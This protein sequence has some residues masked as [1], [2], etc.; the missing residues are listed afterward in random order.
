M[1][2][3][4]FT[5]AVVPGILICYL[6]TKLD[7]Y[8]KERLP[9]LTISLGLGIGIF[10]VAR[11]AEGHFDEWILS[12]YQVEGFNPNTHFGTLF[13]SAFFR[14]GFI[15]EF[16]KLVVLLLIPF[17]HRKF[18]E[19]MDGIVYAVVIG[20]GFAVVE[21]IY[22]CM[23]NNEY[24]LALVR[25][26]TAVP[27]HAVFGVILGYYV[28]LAKFSKNKIKYILQGFLLAVGIH[29]LYDIFLFQEYNDSLMLLATGVLI[30]GLF[31]S[32]KLINTHQ[33]NSPFK[34]TSEE[35]LLIEAENNLNDLEEDNEILSGVISQMKGEENLKNKNQN[36]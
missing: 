17:N 21:N 26:F 14:V 30:G 10:F 28:G 11:Y 16:L 7:R 34:P 22:Y 23:P 35:E 15:E 2:L 36:P 18:N 9:L 20:M 3:L 27:S 5:L 12:Y 31:F 6:I 8:E 19:P 33:I 24:M 25:N 1:S 32:Q 13:L 4:T 29:G